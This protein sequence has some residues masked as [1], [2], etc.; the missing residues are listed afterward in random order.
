L[1]KGDHCV[2]LQNKKKKKGEDEGFSHG[3]GLYSV[4]RQQASSLHRWLSPSNAKLG[5]VG[6]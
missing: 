5:H 1:L 4:D 2:A 3:M 6:T